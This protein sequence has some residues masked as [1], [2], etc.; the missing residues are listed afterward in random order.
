[1]ETV[2]AEESALSV[3][4][5]QYDT[6]E[7]AIEDLQYVLGDRDERLYAT[8]D[9]AVVSKDEHGKVRIVRKHE[10]PVSMGAWGGFV[11]GAVVGL[12][13][14]PALVEVGAIGAAAGAIVGHLTRGMSSSDIK[15]LG[16]SLDAATAALIIAVDSASAERTRSIMGR[17]S[18][19]SE[20]PVAASTTD[21][22]EAIEEATR[23]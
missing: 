20:T 8:F 14:P 4:I 10:S 12:I 17:A 21:I 2:L 1:M 6:V 15:A 16:D 9:A 18:S 22:D 23:V 5:G 7:D 11:V 13:Y 3:I 19:I